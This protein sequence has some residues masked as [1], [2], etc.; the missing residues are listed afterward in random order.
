MSTPS[1]HNV[2]WQS[3]AGP[4]RHLSVGTDTARRYADGFSPI[5]AFADPEHPD[6]AALSPFCAAGERFYAAHW[7]GPAPAGWRIDLDA[8]MVRMVW[9]GGMPADEPAP[10][11]PL[12]AADVAAAMAL[13]TLTKP[14]PFGPRTIEMGDY[15]GVFEDG[16]LVAMAGER[17]CAPGAR[18]VSGVCT[19]PGHQ[20]RGLARRL[21][22]GLIRRELARGE[23]PYLHVMAANAT[24]RG[25][26]GRM[27]FREDAEVPVRVVV[28][29]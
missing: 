4:H 12:G 1:L 17:T 19:H 14:G 9:A 29:T 20:G 5:L 13:A 22:L 28:R 8:T 7:R 16:T 6:F 10:G 26:Y 24:A 18:E 3:L 21:M 15:F 2:F 11:R 27:G 25:L 23:V